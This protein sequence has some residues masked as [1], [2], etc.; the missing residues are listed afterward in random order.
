M[1]SEL[2]SVRISSRGTK[3]SQLRR[4]RRKKPVSPEKSQKCPYYV[5]FF[6]RNW[7]F[8]GRVKKLAFLRTVLRYIPVRDRWK[9]KGRYKKWKWLQA[10]E[11][12]IK[13]RVWITKGLGESCYL[14]PFSFH[15]PRRRLH[16]SL[17]ARW[18]KSRFLHLSSFP[19]LSHLKFKRI[20]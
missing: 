12:W 11:A 19:P 1:K 10:R 20:I 13:R 4:A 8:F 2:E 17:A 3:K 9:M 7:I 6:A 14:L 5:F 15:P 16:P 18:M